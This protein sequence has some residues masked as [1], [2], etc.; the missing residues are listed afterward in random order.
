MKSIAVFC[1]SSEGFNPNNATMAY[2]LGQLL[3]TESIELIYG[4]AKIGLMGAV[5]RGVQ[6]NGGICIGVIPD[7]L[8]QKEIVNLNSDELI[9]TENMHDRKIIM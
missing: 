4:A 9:V 3:A 6:D 7:F 2:E 1:G 8:K 5:A